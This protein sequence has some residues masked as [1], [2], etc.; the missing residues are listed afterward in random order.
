M[1]DYKLMFGVRTSPDGT[2]CSPQIIFLRCNVLD[3]LPRLIL[4]SIFP[5]KTSF[6]RWPPYWGQNIPEISFGIFNMLTSKSDEEWLSHLS[7]GCWCV[8]KWKSM[9]GF[10][11]PAEI[12]LELQTGFLVTH[13]HCPVSLQLNQSECFMGLWPQIPKVCC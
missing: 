9:V 4:F 11:A 1:Y 3:I 7:Y 10:F 13:Y 5:M 2:G 6:G 12:N 8:R